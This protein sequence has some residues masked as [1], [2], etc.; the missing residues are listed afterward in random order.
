MA[1]RIITRGLGSPNL[2]VTRG[3]GD[4]VVF[5]VPGALLVLSTCR[6]WL[7]VVFT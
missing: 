1:N 3:Y 5:R 4:A 6:P 2:L 7:R